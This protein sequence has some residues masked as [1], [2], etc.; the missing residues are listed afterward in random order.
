VLNPGQ[1]D[2]HRLPSAS[3]KQMSFWWQEPGGRLSA[4]TAIIISRAWRKEQFLLFFQTFIQ[5]KQEGQ[6]KESQP[7]QVSG[8]CQALCQAFL[9]KRERCPLLKLQRTAGAPKRCRLL[10]DSSQQRQFSRPTGLGLESLKD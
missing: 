9:W 2:P 5:G 6:A 7:L 8:L 4:S 10:P 3:E 1:S